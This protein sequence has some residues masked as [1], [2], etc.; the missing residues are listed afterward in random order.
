MKKQ[1]IQLKNVRITYPF[2]FQK[3]FW[4]DK[5]ATDTNAKKGKYQITI[6]IPKNHEVVSKLQEQILA[7]KEAKFEGRGSCCLKDI[8]VLR[9]E[10]TSYSDKEY[11]N[12][13]ILTAKNDY[14]PL[15]VENYQSIN[16]ATGKKEQVQITDELKIKSGDYVNVFIELCLS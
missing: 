13:F 11:D 2:L 7:I 12:T 5:E 4:N 10:H 16:S 8:N 15:I 1:I 6:I 3:K 9:E 14:K